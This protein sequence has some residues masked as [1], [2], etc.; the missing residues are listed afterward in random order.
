MVFALFLLCCKVSRQR[1]NLRVAVTLA[2]LVHDGGWARTG[3]KSLHLRHQVGLVQPG[4]RHHTGTF[5]RPTVGAMAVGAGG[6]QAFNVSAS[7][8][9]SACA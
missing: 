7:L 3:L 5:N 6:G 4:N 1:F 8:P 2:E 9:A